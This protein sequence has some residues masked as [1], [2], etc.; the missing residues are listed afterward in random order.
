M[1]KFGSLVSGLNDD[2]NA[3][4]EHYGRVGMGLDPRDE[5]DVLTSQGQGVEMPPPPSARQWIAGKMAGD[6]PF[7]SPRS[8]LTSK[9]MGT[10]GVG[11][12][13]LAPIDLVPGVG[14]AF[15]LNEAIRGGHPQSIAAAMI[16][17]AKAKA[18]EE[19]TA[20]AM[21]EFTSWADAL[22]KETPPQQQP[23]NWVRDRVGLGGV[24]VGSDRTVVDVNVHALD[25][26]HRATDPGNIL[27]KPPRQQVVDHMAAGNPISLPEVAVYKGQLRYSNGRNRVAVAKMMGHDT[28]PVAVDN[29]S[30][31]P[32]QDLLAKHSGEQPNVRQAGQTA[33]TEA[34]AAAAPG[35]LSADVGRGAGGGDARLSE[36]Q[37]RA[38]N[39]AGAYEALPGLP[40]KPVKIG[41]DQFYVPGPIGK[42]KDVAESYMQGRVRSGSHPEPEI[43]HPID[44]EHSANIAQAY[45][46]M[47]HAPDDPAVKASY[48]AMIKETLD[49]YRHI[50]ANHPELHIEPIVGEDPYAANPRMAAMDV[51]HNNH[52]WFFPTES[53]Y[54]TD[55]GNPAAV[56]QISD[57]PLLRPSGETLNGK[58]LLNNDL[59]RVVHDYF[60]HLKE[61]YGFRGAG[62]DNA[63]R[64]H[65][66][67][68]SDL[69]RPA[70]T[71]ETRGQNSWVNYG[72]HGE[73]NRSA[74]G[75][76]TRYADQKVGLMPEW[77]MRDRRK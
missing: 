18:A 28:V 8:E 61:G 73:T 12:P 40:Q 16:P 59:F 11:E 23:I 7:Y 53:G 14:R 69:A 39:A 56:K 58:P 70:M 13:S 47:A 37:A 17:G 52:L 35:S 74:S 48:E 65:A 27:N 62:E 54:G 68:Y 38:T 9:L 3:L 42:V 64:S 19:V 21:K 25:A 63:W 46:E 60:G 41:G 45:E 36:A 22:G 33:A 72:P 75:A 30:L 50:R 67:M 1:P 26:A 51:A 10:S 44:K 71:S 24:P 57:N 55:V 32:L 2:E 15:A 66:S 6:A 5:R 4:L 29:E 34:G 77:T 20:P 43:Y 31:Q 76:D 49:Q